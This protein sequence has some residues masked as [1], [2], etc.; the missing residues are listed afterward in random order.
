MANKVIAL[1]EEGSSPHAEGVLAGYAEV[2]GI[3]SAADVRLLVRSKPRIV[4]LDLAMAYV[5]ANDVL[6]VLREHKV[7]PVVLLNYG[8]QP[9]EVLQ[10]IRQLASLRVA[11]RVSPA[12]LGHIARLLQLS[13][14]SLARV[15]HVS[16]KTVQRWLR[17]K[18]PRPRPRPE[19][20]QLARLTS[21]LEDTFPTQEAVQNYLNR[22]NPA[23][24]GEKPLALL[25]RG[26]YERLE[27]DL[28]AIQEGV[29]A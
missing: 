29:Y 7:Q 28:Q 9:S 22:P 17:G 10:Q 18:R 11:P 12:S 3:R 27:A 1:K 23:L 6:R 25:L 4:L 8:Q 13:Q 26:E 19:L 16:S 15:L 21:M 20:V 5:D 14:E 2:H 24:S